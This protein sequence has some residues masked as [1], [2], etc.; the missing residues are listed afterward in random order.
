MEL[1]EVLLYIYKTIPLTMSVVHIITY[2]STGLQNISEPHAYGV[3]RNE[4]Q[5]RAI[6]EVEYATLQLFHRL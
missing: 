5:H 6:I 2:L 4:Q 3:S 1:L